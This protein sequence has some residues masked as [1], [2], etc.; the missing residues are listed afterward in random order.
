MY[1]Y[2]VLAYAWLASFG[3]A[4]FLTNASLLFPVRIRIHERHQA[5][6]VRRAGDLHSMPPDTPLKIRNDVR[7]RYW[8][9]RAFA[10]YPFCMVCVGLGAWLAGVAVAWL[11]LGLPS[12]VWGTPAWLSIPAALALGWLLMLIVNNLLPSVGMLT[13]YHSVEAPTGPST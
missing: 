6:A 7:T 12:A 2:Q 10:E 1:Q 13:D 3:A 11:H 5:H 9:R 4:Y 8:L